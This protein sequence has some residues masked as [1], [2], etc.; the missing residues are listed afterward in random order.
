M[1]RGSDGSSLSAELLS[2]IMVGLHRRREDEGGPH[3]R[4]A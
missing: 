1:I 3:R 2:S 4:A